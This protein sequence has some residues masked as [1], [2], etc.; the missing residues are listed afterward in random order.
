MISAVTTDFLLQKRPS[1]AANDIGAY[2]MQ[3]AGGTISTHAEFDFNGDGRSDILWRNNQDGRNTIW[4]SANATTQ[5]ATTGVTDMAWK[6]VGTG[7]FDGDGKAD[8]LWRN[9]NDGRNAI[10]K[11]GNAATQQ[12]TTGVTDRAWIV[13]L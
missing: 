1:G 9:A 10:W 2:E 12:V 6:V 11:S 13:V 4:Q 7:D 5:Q 3:A 8:I